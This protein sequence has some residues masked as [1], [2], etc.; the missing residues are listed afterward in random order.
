MLTNIIVIKKDGSK[1]PFDIE[2]TVDAINRAAQDINI[3]LT[4]AEIQTLKHA[5]LE[6]VDSHEIL[7]PQDLH[8]LA[9]KAA[10]TLNP[11]IAKS[12]KDFHDKKQSLKI[13]DLYALKVVKKDSTVEN[14]NWDEIINAAQKA[15]ETTGQL[16]SDVELSQLMDA[17]AHYA[18]SYHDI[19]STEQLHRL[20]MGG[21]NMVRPDVYQAYKAYRK[22]REQEAQSFREL[23]DTAESIKYVGMNEN[24]NKDSQVITTRAALTTEATMKK[25]FAV[26]CPPKIKEAHEK[27]F[28]YI[29]D[30]GD[31]YKDTFNCDN[32]DFGHLIKDKQH[33]DGVYAFKI[34]NKITHEPKHV[35][36]AFDILSSATIAM[37][38]NQFGLTYLP[39]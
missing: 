18:V 11:A 39:N 9:I 14:F 10:N 30:F 3:D 2:K 6:R 16:M 31:L 32:V 24:A 25:L 5:I 34:N 38:G 19:I 8:A 20:V 15:A 12:Y 37:S 36:S 1:Q 17:V 23:F 22:Q 33:D 4:A 21:L 13:S 35:S 28:V 29:H 26:I 27:G 7:L